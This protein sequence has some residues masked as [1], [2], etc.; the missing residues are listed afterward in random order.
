MTLGPQSRIVIAGAGRVGCYLGGRLAAA[1]R[2]VTLLLRDKL[3]NAISTSGLRVSDLDGADRTLPAASL[4]PTADAKTALTDAEI[5]LL[6]VKCRDTKEM[7]ELVARRAPANTVI[8]SL[9][10]G[11]DNVAILERTLG[12]ESR[13]IGGMVP[14]NVVQTL[15]DGEAPHFH[16]ASSGK[17][18][19]GTGVEGL[20]ELL[21]VAG[22]RVAEQPDIRPVL[23]AKLLIN[24]N[25]ALNALANLPLAAQLGDRRWRLLLAAQIHEGLGALRAA[26]I[27]AGRIEGIHPRLSALVLRLRNPLFNLAARRMLA[28]DRNARSSMW[29]DL[30]ARR[31][32]E[33]EFIQGKIVSL[34]EKH[35]LTAP[36]NQRVMQ[37]IKEAELANNGSPGLTPEAVAGLSRNHKG[38]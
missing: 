30:Q 17:I 29:E 14:F 19:T 23:W 22:A 13:V 26:G 35:G 18:Q 6:T 10:N 38:V 32:T 34:A 37:L 4:N 12:P 33:I 36:L 24:L 31:P 11:V 3:A 9:Q 20:R 7:A 8:V 27:E 16:R 5:V 1:G 28:F 21:D 2:N 25:N 15:K